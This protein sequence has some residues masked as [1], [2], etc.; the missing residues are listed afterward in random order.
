MIN[1]T[2]EYRVIRY[3]LEGPRAG[4][5]ETLIDELPGFPDNITTGL[6]GR[7]WIALV[8]PTNRLLDS[9][10]GMPFVR[11]MI[12][13]LPAFVRP[14]AELYGHIIAVNAIGEVVEN[15][16]DP[17]AGYPINTGVA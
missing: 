13:R 1:E 3:W 7:F 6:E 5:S 10:S 2:G 16:H 8:S 17:A 12:Q 4:Q 15:L 14:E 9:L 11:K